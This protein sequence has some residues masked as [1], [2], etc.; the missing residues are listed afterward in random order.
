[1]TTILIQSDFEKALI[2]KKP[3]NIDK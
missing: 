3:A 2:E 1:M